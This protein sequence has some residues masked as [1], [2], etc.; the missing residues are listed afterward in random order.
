MIEIT[1]DVKTLPKGVTCFW[2]ERQS[3]AVVYLSDDDTKIV[4]LPE[5]RNTKFGA[6]QEVNNWLA[7]TTAKKNLKVKNA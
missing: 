1:D 2:A 5:M 6:I 7:K 3:V 4:P